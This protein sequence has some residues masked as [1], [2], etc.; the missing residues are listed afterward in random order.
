MEMVVL[1]NEPEV[2]MENISNK[3]NRDTSAAPGL[4]LYRCVA[5][6]FGLLCILQIALN[7]SLRPPLNHTNCISNSEDMTT[8]LTEERDELKRKLDDLK[9]HQNVLKSERDELKR[10]LNDFAHR[11]NNG[12]LYFSHSFYY[13][14]PIKKTWHDSRNDCLQREADLVI[15]NSK[16]EQEFIQRWVK[17][18]MWIGLSKRDGI[19][20]W[21]VVRW[22]T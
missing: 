4:K 11:S 13:I 5:V 7:I 3:D 6:S 9:S 2:L 20:K 10:T 15:I 16:E 1:E 22:G 21:L 17:N 12:W 18:L 19:W 8:N 14:S